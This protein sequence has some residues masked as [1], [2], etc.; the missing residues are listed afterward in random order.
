[1]L[2]RS[3]DIPLESGESLLFQLDR[4]CSR[5]VEIDRRDAWIEGGNCVL[6][7]VALVSDHD[8]SHSGV[9]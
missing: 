8:L 7:V 3:Q 5:V 2:Q 6:V 1:M 4:R 9:V